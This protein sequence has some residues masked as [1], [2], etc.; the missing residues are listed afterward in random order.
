MK[1]KSKIQLVLWT[2]LLVVAIPLSAYG[3]DGQIKISQPASFPIVIDEP[4]S[5]VLTSNIIATSG[6][7]AIEITADD[8][9][10]DLNGHAVVCPSGTGISANDKHNIIIENGTVT[11]CYTGV[12][13]IYGAN[14]Y[15]IQIKNMNV[16]DNGWGGG[17]LAQNAIISN[18]TANNNG[19]YGFHVAYSTLTNCT[20][21][22]NTVNSGFSVY[23]SI[24]TNCIARGNH[25]LAGIQGSSSIITN[26]V[27][28]NNNKSGI[29]AQDNCRVEGNNVRANGE[30]G[31]YLSGAGN[32]AIKNT[33]SGNASGNFYSGD[34][35]NYMPTTGDNANIG[36]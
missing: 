26:C 2:L 1:T 8:V 6:G 9:T 35:S 3:V 34:P 24:V 7:K 15:G 12:E 20:A 29:Y 16:S 17:I 21:N 4:G 14:I 22:N 19:N 27:A 18:C 28:S 23:A 11:G 36:W 31:L 32:Y 10:L 25:L 33:A 30:C 13:I 5:Y